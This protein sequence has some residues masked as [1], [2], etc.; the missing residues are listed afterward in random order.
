MV[1]VR[2]AVELGGDYID[3]MPLWRQIA[4]GGIVVFDVPGHH[5]EMVASNAKAVAAALD[6]V[7]GPGA[8]PVAEL[9]KRTRSL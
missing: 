4:R 9:E 7:L 5:L 2:A 1:H 6:Q 8:A 3:P